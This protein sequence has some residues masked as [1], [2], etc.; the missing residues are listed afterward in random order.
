MADYVRNKYPND[1]KII[2]I[3]K[4][5]EDKTIADKLFLRW[6]S[7]GYPSYKDDTNLKI[8]LMN[9]GYIVNVNASDSIQDESGNW[10]ISRNGLSEKLKVTPIG[11]KAV[12]S[13]ELRS[14]KYDYVITKLPNWVAI[15]ISIIALLISIF[16]PLMLWFH[17]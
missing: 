17:R 6:L 4:L 1:H 8:D 13:T 16:Q 7:S 5:K 15:L 3:L 10:V 9:D 14:E 12:N 11:C 2:Y